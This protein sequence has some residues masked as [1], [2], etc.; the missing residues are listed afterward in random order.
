MN[1]PQ[2]R[3]L[4]GSPMVTEVVQ[5]RVEGQSMLTRR[6]QLLAE[7]RELQAELSAY[8]KE[9]KERG[10]QIICNVDSKYQTLNNRIQGLGAMLLFMTNAKNVNRDLNQRLSFDETKIKMYQLERVLNQI[11][12]YTRSPAGNDIDDRLRGM[13]YEVCSIGDVVIRSYHEDARS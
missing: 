1:I 13:L 7:Q 5:D 6:E 3:V 8:V 12:N 4:R 11:T 9:K 10:E 2:R